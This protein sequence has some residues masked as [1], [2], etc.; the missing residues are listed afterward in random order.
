M[1]MQRQTTA[2]RLE[3]APNMP[4]TPRSGSFQAATTAGNSNRVVGLF[5]GAPKGVK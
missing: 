5:H 3:Q 4:D 2:V 1:T